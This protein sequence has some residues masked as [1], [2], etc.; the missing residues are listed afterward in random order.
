MNGLD[1]CPTIILFLVDFRLALRLLSSQPFM[2]Q[3]IRAKVFLSHWLV[4]HHF[5]PGKPGKISPSLLMGFAVGGD[6]VG[7]GRNG[8]F[9]VASAPEP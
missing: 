5:L 2:A 1:E 9:Q 8:P 6:G 3:G 4:V 7:V